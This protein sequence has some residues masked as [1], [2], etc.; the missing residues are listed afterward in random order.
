V[1]TMFRSRA[2]AK[3]SAT[4]RLD[5][6]IKV[7]TVSGWLSLAVGLTLV[8]ALVGWAVLGTTSDEVGGRAILV[9][10]PH[11]FL[12]ESPVQGTVVQA[13]PPAG[14]AVAAG[15]LLAWIRPGDDPDGKPLAIYASITGTVISSDAGLGTSV[16]PG[17][18]LAYL[19]LAGAPLVAQVFVPTRSGLLVEVGMAAT[20][21]P[22]VAPSATYGLLRAT[23]EG[24]SEVSLSPD[25]IET[26]TGNPVLAAEIVAGPPVLLITLALEPGT[27]GRQ[28][29]WTSGT[30]PPF[31]LQ[32]GTLA[33]ATVVLG[34]G[35]PLDDLFGHSRT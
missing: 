22:S 35:R 18:D 27:D 1:S 13:P 30:G 23:V 19:S 21:S 4:E 6:R 15:E 5:E 16:Q 29:A 11:P 32:S 20:V 10:E 12:I 2:V 31:T 24:V 7:V 26:I 3:A 8:L 9:R 33:Q 17:Q 14:T 25:R 28:F 34:T